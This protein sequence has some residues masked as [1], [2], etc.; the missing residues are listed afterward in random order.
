MLFSLYS[1]V[2][3]G[4]I[5]QEKSKLSASSSKIMMIDFRTLVNGIFNGWIAAGEARSGF[6][7]AHVLKDFD[8]LRY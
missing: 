5:E 8:F 1:V 2:L 4:R 6:R 7:I 3:H